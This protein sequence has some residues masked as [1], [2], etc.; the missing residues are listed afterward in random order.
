MSS[1]ANKKI[2][3]NTLYL[4]FRMGVIMLVKLYTTRVL[5]SALGVADYGTWNIVA[6]F[7][8]TFSTISSPLVASV[9]RFLNY[10]MGQGGKRLNDIFNTGFELFAAAALIMLFVLETGGL[11]FVNNKMNFTPDSMRVVNIIF[12]FAIFSFVFQLIQKPYEAVI[13]AHEKMSFYALISMIEAFCFLSIALLIKFD[14]PGNKLELYSIL[15]FATAVLIFFSYKIYCNRKFVISR[16]KPIFDRKLLKEM[17]VFSGWNIFGSLSSITSNEGVNILLN[18]FYGVTLNAA[19]GIAQQMKTAAMMVT[20]NIQKAFEPQIVKNYSASNLERVRTLASVALKLSY[21]LAFIF[22]LP[23]IMNMEFILNV[24]LS[25]DIPPY[26][27]WLGVL[28]LV[29]ILLLSFDGTIDSVIYSTGK[30]RNYILWVSGINLLN[31]VFTYILFSRGIGPVSAFVVKVGV[32]LVC[33]GAR[34]IFLGKALEISMG[35]ILGK[36]IL[37]VSWVTLLTTGFIFLLMWWIKPG[38]SFLRISL[39]LCYLPVA[40]ICAWVWLLDTSQKRAV[41]DK[42]FPKASR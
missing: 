23:L 6:A 12:Q 42:L 28:T 41:K 31:I 21:F 29:Q 4:Y 34:F 25:K 17:S 24:W 14:I 30:I 35:R 5:L 33:Q 40:L 18:I 19:Y 1:S 38:S 7:V 15:N 9:Q 2:A 26:T 20:S 27:Y 39:S 32:E 22:I 13:I 8:V 3:R 10:D 16:L 11:W 36:M 37:P